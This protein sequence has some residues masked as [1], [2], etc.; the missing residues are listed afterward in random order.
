M[1]SGAMSRMYRAEVPLYTDL[2]SLVGE[3]NETVLRSDPELRNRLRKLDNLDRISEERH[4]AIRLGRPDELHTIRRLFS[5]MGME[6]VGY[7][8]LS[9]AGLPVHATAFRPVS[10]EE[11][12]RNPFRVFTSLLRSEL[13]EPK[14][15]RDEAA[16][17]LAKRDIFGPVLRE[18]IDHAEATGGVESG[19]AEGFIDEAVR[20]FSWRSQAIVTATTYLKLHV[21]HR[22]AADIVSFKGPHINHL[23]PRVLDID[24]AQESMTARGMDA[25]A[26]IEGPP[27]R[28][29]PVLLRQTSFK[30]LQE[31]I[32]FLGEGGAGVPGT[33]TAR[34]GEIEQRGIALTRKGRDLYDS[35]LREARSIEPPAAD[36]LNADRYMYALTESFRRFPDTHED[37]RR[38]GLAFYQYF[39]TEKHSLAETMDLESMIK[40]GHVDFE[41]IV[42]EDFLPISAAGIFQS[43]LGDR[44]TAEALAV[45]N[46]E[47]FVAAL[48]T[49]PLDEFGLYQAIEDQSKAAIGLRQ[50]REF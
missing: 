14:E 29:C 43:N 13:I 15:V 40:A 9:V 27:R 32:S 22:L 24:A 2:L 46:R 48:G 33:H 38:D 41:P 49:E 35:C 28:K 37:M 45:S 44:K 31:Q 10:A 1:F 47:Q 19:M 4:G 25:K 23:T 42:Y 36:G 6:P 3:I 30:A 18:L 7:Y 26:V 16:A 5:I 39:I 50:S 20:M 21:S 34:F 11:L 17:I 12:R 8:D